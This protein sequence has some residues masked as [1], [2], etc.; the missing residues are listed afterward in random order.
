M[1]SQCQRMLRA[2]YPRPLTYL[3]VSSLGGEPPLLEYIKTRTQPI[4]F[5][6][7]F[8]QK[9]SIPIPRS[10]PVL[11]FPIK[12]LANRRHHRG[13]FWEY[14]L[15]C[16]WHEVNHY[17]RFSQSHNWLLCYYWY[18]AFNGTT[19]LRFCAHG[20]GCDFVKKHSSGTVPCSTG[21]ELRVL[22]VVSYSGS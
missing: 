19:P 16:L 15:Q 2:K 17:S 8:S 12:A 1:R 11:S 4:P 22:R 18:C 20:L 9:L 7:K 3:P 14:N 5:S 6:S 10:I 21:L 13:V